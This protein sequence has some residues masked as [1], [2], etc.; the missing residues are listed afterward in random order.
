M[1]NF[2]NE[3]PENFVFERSEL[4]FSVNGEDLESSK[5]NMAK[6]LDTF[7]DRKYQHLAPVV[8]A[9]TFI[10]RFAVG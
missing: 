3:R 10:G 9:A 2:W 5:L 1:K 7:H 6:S 8:A 4:K